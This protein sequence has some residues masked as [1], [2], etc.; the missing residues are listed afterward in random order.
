VRDGGSANTNFGTVNELPVKLDTAGFVRESF[1]QFDVTGLGDIASAKLRLTPVSGATD[2]GTALS[3]EFVAVD[4]WTEAGITWNT[5]PAGSGT[6]LGTRTGYTLLSP[7]KIDVAGKTQTEAAGDGRLSLRIFAT[8]AGSSKIVGFASREHGEAAYRPALEYLLAGPAAPADVKAVLDS[9]SVSITWMPSPG[10][11]SYVVK[12]ATSKG[13]PYRILA[14][15]LTSTSYVDT[16][17]ADGEVYYY[18]VCGVNAE[19]QG[20]GSPELALA[21]GQARPRA[22][23]RFDETSG[24]RAADSSGNA[25]DGD[26]I[27]GPAWLAGSNARINGAVA[28]DGVNDHVVLPA[29]VMN[30]LADFT[31]STWVR[32]ES[33]STWSRIFDFGFGSGGNTMYLTPR[34]SSS[35]GPVRFGIRVG[36]TSQVIE[37]KSALPAGEWVHVAVTLSGT[38]GTLY[39]NG[40]AVGTNPA[41]TFKPSSLGV[42]TLNYLGRSQST[43]D[44]YLRGALDEFKIFGR[45]LLPSEVVRLANPPPPPVITSATTAAGTYNAAFTYGITATNTPTSFTATALPSGLLVDSSTGVISGTPSSAGEYSVKLGASN[46]GGTGT[47]LLNLSIAKAAALVNISNLQ[48]VYDGS[49]KAA[50]V[51]TAPSGLALTV[52]YDGVAQAPVNAGTYKVDAKVVDPNYAGAGSAFLEITKATAQVQISGLTRAYDGAP[53]PVTTVTQPANLPVAVT[54]DGSADP[55]VYP[56]YHDV[57]ATVQ[58]A[59]YTGSA[60]ARLLITISA[61]VRHAPQLNGLVDGSA[62]MLLG[63]SLVLQSSATVAGD[64]LVPGSPAVVVNGSPTYVGQKTGPGAA[65]PANYSVTLNSGSVLRY[66]VSRVDPIDL[67]AVATPPRPSGTRS[68]TMDRATDPVGDFGT[69]R[70]LTLNSGAGSVVVPPGVYGQFTVNN[71]SALVLGVPG[72]SGPVEYAFESLTLNGNQPIKVVG[73][74][75]IT[76]A[77]GISLNGTVGEEAHP[78]WLTLRFSSGGLSLNSGATF[79]GVIVAPSG[80][81]TINGNTSVHGRIMADRLMINSNGSLRDPSLP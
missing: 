1:L 71:K 79:Y 24:N 65:L 74:V 46:D 16:D 3:Y 35:T 25:W 6:V 63:E 2:S 72:S 62:Q 49:P 51:T 68:V 12:R 40:E 44:P 26:L 30:G 64:L 58:D 19:N 61:L 33:V 66:L 54:Y 42:T 9:G 43:S 11:L 29:G 10:A 39:V 15:N 76:V 7:V 60:S 69:L 31:V 20:A 28:F 23:L 45:A 22:H 32:L 36:S 17:V 38:T 59:N 55:S 4:S 27:N 53:K 8:V 75:I 80:T 78:E 67:P 47:A 81:V 70:N 56:G 50:V 48:H 41:M 77:G 13:G 52:T 18:V 21:V 14:A 73:E 37:G 5:K 57:V 34:A